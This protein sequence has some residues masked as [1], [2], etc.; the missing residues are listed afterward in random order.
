[1]DPHPGH[2]PET[3]RDDPVAADLRSGDVAG[4]RS[5]GIV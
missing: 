5:A 4:L 2:A 1:M 3:A